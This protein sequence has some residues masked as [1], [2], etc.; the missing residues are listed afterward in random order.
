MAVLIC[1]LLL[2]TTYVTSNNKIQ[3]SSRSGFLVFAGLC[4]VAY[5]VFGLLLA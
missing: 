1:L 2:T 3:D 4:L 5:I